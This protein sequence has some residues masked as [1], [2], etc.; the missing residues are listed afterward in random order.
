MPFRSKTTRPPWKKGGKI[1]F[2]STSSEPSLS[3]FHGLRVS[4]T[5][6]FTLKNTE[7]RTQVVCKWS[8]LVCLHLF[9]YL[10]KKWCKKD[11]GAEKI[12]GKIWVK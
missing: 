4:I 12:L 9:L 10:M 3:G 1:C 2:L 11:S 7:D 8:V 5:A 6:K